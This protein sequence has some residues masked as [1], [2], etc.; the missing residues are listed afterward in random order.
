MEAV[1]SQ[2]SGKQSA[3]AD[4]E[5]R[6]GHNRWSRIFLSLPFLGATIWVLID[7]WTSDDNWTLRDAWP[8]LLA[9]GVL[10]LLMMRPSVRITPDELWICI[11]LTRKIPRAEVESAK[12][13]YHGLVIHRRDGGSE[14]ALLA[15][16]LTSTELSW[17]GQPEP[18]SA[19]YE[20]TR[21][22]EQYTAD[23]S[24]PGSE[25]DH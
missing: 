23:D 10:S 25:R 20:I 7:E 6:W 4:G 22:A 16:R 2:S 1:V 13:N 12:F 24:L 14:F 3:Y 15:P 8:M 21:W 17:A 19:A 11:L 5:L 18:G 9:L